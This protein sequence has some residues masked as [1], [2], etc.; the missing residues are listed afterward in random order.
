VNSVLSWMT[1]RAKP[2]PP[3]N[4]VDTLLELS[5]LLAAGLTPD[6][7]WQELARSRG[8]MSVSAEVF[9][10]RE[11]GNAVADS[12]EEVTL[13]LSRPWRT[14]G[15]A[16]E[17]ARISGAPL[18]PAL[19]SLAQSLASQDETRRQIDAELA[20]PQATLRLVSLLPLPALAGG[21]LGGVDTVSFL[22]TTL[23]GRMT[24]GIGLGCLI[25]A[26]W[27]MRIMVTR[28][29][30]SRVLPSARPDLFLLALGGGMSP[31]RALSCTDEMMAKYELSPPAIDDLPELLELSHRTGAPLARLISARGER[32]HSV[33]RSESARAVGT[34]SVHLVL[35]LGLLVLPG[36]VLI[37]V[38]PLAWGIWNQGVLA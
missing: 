16:W 21:F 33:E 26:W 34:L 30:E 25:L 17:L 10:L 20:A 36:F 12:I 4:P 29:V 35:P 19:R 18:G 8:D 27:W 38:V 23:P 5:E 1:S 6:R 2:G 22:V 14:L 32:A 37:A 28:V 31:R 3:E 11:T 15:A 7:A 24:L 13:V 9:R